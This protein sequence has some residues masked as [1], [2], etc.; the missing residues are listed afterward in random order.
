LLE[1]A[2]DIDEG[3]AE[4]LGDGGPERR[5]PGAHEADQRQVTG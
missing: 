1:C 3:A 4:P 2:V 5:L